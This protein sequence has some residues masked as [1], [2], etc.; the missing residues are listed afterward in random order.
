MAVSHS[1]AFTAFCTFENPSTPGSPTP[2][3]EGNNKL[4]LKKKSSGQK[5]NKKETN[6]QIKSKKRMYLPQR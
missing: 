3:E 4:N 2:S 5:E 6:K 1:R